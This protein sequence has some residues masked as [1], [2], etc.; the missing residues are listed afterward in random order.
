MRNSDYVP[1][2]SPPKKPPPKPPVPPKP[3]ITK[4]LPPFPPTP[5]VIN[6][7]M[8]SSED[9]GRSRTNS[10]DV[11]DSPRPEMNL[12]IWVENKLNSLKCDEYN[13][14]LEIREK[15]CQNLKVD[16][17][18]YSIREK[19]KTKIIDEKDLIVEYRDKVL[20]LINNNQ[21]TKPSDNSV[22]V[23]FD[24]ELPD[25]THSHIFL[26][27]YSSVEDVIE[28]I[29]K[30]RAI[31]NPKEYVLCIMKKNR[32]Y[33]IPGETSI[34]GYQKRMLFLNKKQKDIKKVLSKEEMEIIDKNFEKKG[35]IELKIE[36]R[37]ENSIEISSDPSL[38]VE[39]NHEQLDFKFF[40]EYMKKEREMK[41]LF[42]NQVITKCPS[43]YLDHSLKHA[44]I[45]L[46][47]K[48]IDLFLCGDL[49]FSSLVTS[50]EENNRE[51]FVEMITKLFESKSNM[52]NLLKLLS[53]QISPKINSKSLFSGTPIVCSFLTAYSFKFIH[54]FL[55]PSIK[56]VLEEFDE[57]LNLEIV[58][59][60]LP[61]GVSQI[62][63]SKNLVAFIEMF[64]NEM[65][66]IYSRPF[67]VNLK[68]F[69]NHFKNR[70]LK[71]LE[72]DVVT[73]LLSIFIFRHMICP[74]LKDPKSFEHI[75]ELKK[76]QINT[77]YFEL[78]AI[79]LECVSSGMPFERNMEVMEQ[80]R[81]KLISKTDSFVNISVSKIQDTNVQMAQFVEKNSLEEEE[82]DYNPEDILSVLSQVKV[83]LFYQLFQ[84]GY[85]KEEI[86]YLSSSLI[87]LK[88]DEKKFVFQNNYSR[89]FS[90]IS[91]FLSNSSYFLRE[92]MHL[93]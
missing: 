6:E 78:V 93:L 52:I 55:Q 39:I 56:K 72:K 63:N 48:V 62:N 13:T 42:Y 3:I 50:V 23:I 27:K 4:K 53:N 43:Q 88:K 85:S 70:M 69:L 84:D 49:W 90:E 45:E 12:R 89:N 59:S 33:E 16:P 66:L 46:C 28:K 61:E 51:Q 10:I 75:S 38:K 58:N 37:N 67:P 36:N 73:R 14:I 2:S 86:Q 87:E 65:N 7:L 11:I 29:C 40:R 18:L 25:K 76:K 35:S 30:K 81:G 83:N 24:I 8:V 31:T 54:A 60:R 20:V 82:I 80:Y 74:V 17:S 5:K 9:L 34:F 44:N 92:Q 64:V 68:Y 47:F 79:V 19:E 1:S 57:H 21:I 15:I 22:N 91:A 32:F 77:R 71:T 26:D 41:I